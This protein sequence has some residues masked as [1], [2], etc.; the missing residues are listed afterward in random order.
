MYL[1]SDTSFSCYSQ[2]TPLAGQDNGLTL[3]N[4]VKYFKN[5]V[6]LSL[7]RGNE[8]N[9]FHVKRTVNR[10][11]TWQGAGE[12]S[13]FLTGLKTKLHYQNSYGPWPTQALPASFKNFYALPSE[14]RTD[15]PFCD[16]EWTSH[17]MWAY[18][19]PVPNFG[20]CE[21]Q[22]SRYRTPLSAPLGMVSLST[23]FIYLEWTK[24]GRG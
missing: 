3:T 24:R 5:P 2:L 21:Q 23:C 8:F 18:K 19:Q 13:V 11:Y 1:H 20:N 14:N 12:S 16:S 6:P 7:L 22:H 10:K 9:I 15:Q 4:V 17:G